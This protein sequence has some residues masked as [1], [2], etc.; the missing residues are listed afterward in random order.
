MNRAWIFL[1]AAG[2]F[3]LAGCAALQ[4]YAALGNVDFSLDRVSSLRVAGIDLSRVNSFNDIGFSDAAVLISSVAQ[5]RLPMAFQLHV[6]AE[7][8]VDNRVDARLM[9]MGWTLFLQDRETLSG[10]LDQEYLLPPGQPTDIPITISL[11]LLEFFD[12]NAEDLLELALSLANQGGEPKEV[13][14]RATP[15]VD[16]PIGPIRYPRPITILSREVGQ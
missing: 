10:V 4:Q 3:F 12:G 15:V 14:L 8:P 16:T 1:S 6:T 2:L 5:N 7:N 9:E 11:D 13:A